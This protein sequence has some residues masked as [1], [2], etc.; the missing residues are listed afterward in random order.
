[1]MRGFLVVLAVLVAALP[2]RADEAPTIDLAGCLL[3]D[4]ANAR[5]AVRAEL[6]LPDERLDPVVIT[7]VC[8][9]SSAAI[10]EVATSPTGVALRKRVAFGDLAGDQRLRLVALVVAELVTLALASVPTLPS[11]PRPTTT[12]PA[13]SAPAPAPSAPSAPSVWHRRALASDA[14]VASAPHGFVASG[15]RS[16]LDRPAPMLDLAVGASRGPF[17][18]DLFAATRS[19]DDTLGTTRALLGGVGARAT[20]VCGG[21][22]ATWVCLSGRAAAGVAAVTATPVSRLVV[23]RDAYAPYA[24][25][26]QRLEIRVEDGHW[27][28]ELAVALGWSWGLAASAD[29]RELVRLSGAVLAGGL[30]LGWSP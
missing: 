21:G 23:G 28:A 13:P 4:A 8:P 3:F 17:A 12:P 16:F 30:A 18:L 5:R 19:T 27:F 20:F 6:A 10:V 24:E 14:I 22:G 1:M 26:G 15:V 9:D 11:P 2:A 25:V 7:I 29:D